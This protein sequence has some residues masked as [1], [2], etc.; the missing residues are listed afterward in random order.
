MKAGYAA[1]TADEVT[2]LARQYLV[3]KNASTC[4]ITPK[5]VTPPKK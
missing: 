2:A 3:R 4:V 1:I 5:K